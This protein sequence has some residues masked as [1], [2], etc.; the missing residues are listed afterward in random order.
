MGLSSFRRAVRNYAKPFSCQMSLRHH[1]HSPSNSLSLQALHTLPPVLSA[2]VGHK[3]TKTLCC[4]CQEWFFPLGEGRW[5]PAAQTG[6]FWGSFNSFCPCSC[7]MPRADREEEDKIP[8]LALRNSLEWC[9]TPDSRDVLW[10]W[11]SIHPL[12]STWLLS[13]GFHQ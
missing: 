13:V 6:L 5:N 10:L 9:C 1:R 4:L 7:A 8:H 11:S 3:P 2:V 12:R